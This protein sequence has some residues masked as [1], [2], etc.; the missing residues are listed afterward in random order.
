M[1]GAGLWARAAALALGCGGTGT[2]APGQGA[3]TLVGW[4][5]QTWGRAAGAAPPL[6]EKEHNFLN[7]FY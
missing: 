4:A 3:G 5:G 1:L 7:F 2:R 6:E